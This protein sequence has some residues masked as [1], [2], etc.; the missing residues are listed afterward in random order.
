MCLGLTYYEGRTS[1]GELLNMFDVMIG[2]FD[3]FY[4]LFTQLS[5]FIRSKELLNMFDVVIGFSKMS[6]E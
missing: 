3:G 5:P 6:L 1:L 2:L 4:C